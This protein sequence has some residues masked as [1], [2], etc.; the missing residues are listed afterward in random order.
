MLR[1]YL[2][3]ERKKKIRKEGKWNTISNDKEGGKMHVG[4]I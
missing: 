3:E 4:E 2:K 1:K